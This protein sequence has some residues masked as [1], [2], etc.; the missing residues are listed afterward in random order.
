MSPAPSMRPTSADLRALLQRHQPPCISIYEPTHRGYPRSSDEDPVR[1]RNL[2]RQ[3]EVALRAKYPPRR[4]RPILKKFERYLEDTDFWIHA[5]EGLAVFGSP[6]DFRI[7]KLQQP[8]PELLSVADSFHIKPLVR[9]LQRD[10][11]YQILAL[12]LSEAKLYEGT[13]DWL[14]RVDLTGIP[15]TLTEALGTEVTEPFLKATR[16]YG[17]GAGGPAPMYHGQGDRKDE[18]NL[19]RDR[20]F[21][22]IDRQIHERF[23]NRSRLPLVLAALPEHQAH[24]RELSHNPLL[25][26]RGVETNPEALSVDE[27]RRAAWDAALE[28]FF[29]E[30]LGKLKADYTEARAHGRGSDNPEEVAEALAQGRVGTLLVEADRRLPGKVNVLTGTITYTD[31][32]AGTDP[33]PDATG[34]DVLDDLAEAVLRTRGEVVIAPREEMPSTTGLAAIYR[35]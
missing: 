22:I 7:Y 4:F 10:E 26:P 17:G 27:L 9:V 8:V 23:S 2:L 13:R 29:R 16:S 31:T 30:R 3:A 12:T 20:F 5:T 24:F 15:A 1:Y 28:P 32:G 11:R 21:R 19:D 25:L 18:R 35:F 6:D 14:D 34:D 33:S